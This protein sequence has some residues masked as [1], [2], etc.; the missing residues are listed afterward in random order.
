M[1]YSPVCAKRKV[2]KK[3]RRW[4]GLLRGGGGENVRKELLK[5]VVSEK[6]DA[7]CLYFVIYIK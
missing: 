4:M 2:G 7:L 3:V 5:K 1:F 6:C